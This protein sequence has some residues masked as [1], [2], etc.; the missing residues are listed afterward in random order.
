MVVTNEKHRDICEKHWQ[1]HAGTN[2]AK[3]RLH[4]VAQD[5]AMKD[6]KMKVY[7]IMCNNNMKAGP[8]I[9]EDRM[10]GWREPRKF[11]IV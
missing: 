9:N 10:P 2:P 3:V 8:N 6:G 1:I 7:R 4:A 5:R 11:I